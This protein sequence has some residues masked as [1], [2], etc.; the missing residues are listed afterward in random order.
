[1]RAGEV[2]YESPDIEDIRAR[3]QSQLRAVHPSVKR[4]LN[5]HQYPAGIEQRLHELRTRLILEA[6]GINSAVRSRDSG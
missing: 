1:M 3:V 5:P 6:R 4:F 2:V